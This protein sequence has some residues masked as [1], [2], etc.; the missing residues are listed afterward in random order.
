MKTNVGVFFGGRSVEHE[1]SVLSALQAI[2]AMDKEKYDIIPIYITKKGH[3]L[4]GDALLDINNYKN[5][6]SLEA[7]ATEVYMRPVY[8][9]YNLYPVRRKGF[10]TKSDAPLAQLHVALPVLHGTNGE[11]GIFEGVLETIGIPFAGCNTLSSANGMDK[12][13]MKM[14]LRSEGIPVVDYVWFTDKQWLSDRDAIVERVEKE[15][16]YPVI[17]K[18]ANLGS[19]VG[20]GKASD[21]EQLIA[22]ID[23]AEKFSQRL[24]VEHCIDRLKEINCSVLGDVDDH[25]SSVCE[26]PIKSGDFLSYEDKYMGGTKTE[27]GMQ[28]SA[29]RIPA[30]LPDEVSE[31]IRHMAAE[32]FRVLG[33]HGVSRIDVMIDEAD[34]N[35]YVN[36]INTIPG[37]LSFYLWE[38]TG[39]T[40]PQLMDR[41]VQLAIRRKRDTDRKTFTYSHNIFA[42]KGGLKGGAKGGL[43][44]GMKK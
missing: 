40:F 4:T 12:I 19:S 33:C 5:L 17:V 43:K 30:E 32:T 24:I 35:I 7:K 39:I 21:R 27:S 6:D 3:W 10:F 36:E 41:L 9:D 22:K 31:K 13:T 25:Q 15:L 29:K 14:I 1:I 2:A 34:G 44:G 37:S 23:N 38:A 20:I 26:E 11:D 8:G 18:P 42:M 16:G 28:A